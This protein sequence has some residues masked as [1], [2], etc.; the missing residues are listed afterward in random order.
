[1]LGVRGYER[2]RVGVGSVASDPRAARIRAERGWVPRPDL[3]AQV[4]ESM[5]R[6]SGR[7]SGSA[8]GLWLPLKRRF[9]PERSNP[10]RRA[11]KLAGLLA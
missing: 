7:L 2:G 4:I 6:G 8:L 10:D 3:K 1:M 11:T 5:G 9:A